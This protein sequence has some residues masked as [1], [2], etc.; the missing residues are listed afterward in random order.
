MTLLQF[1]IGSL[2]DLVDA[3]ADAG[4][5][6]GKPIPAGLVRPPE[7]AVVVVASAV[8][9]M[10]LA[11]SF[12]PGLAAVAA[13]GLAVGF[14]YDLR[15]KGTTISWL[16]L[17]VGIPLLPVFGWYGATGELP[18]MFLVVVPAAANA[19]AALAISNALVDMERDQDATAGS[20][21]I[22]LGARRAGL[23]VIGLFAVVAALAVGTAF[24]LGAPLGW[25]G[26]VAAACLVPLGGAVLGA[27][28]ARRPGT[29]W[30]ETAFEVQ[31]VGTGLVAVAWLGALSAAGQPPIAL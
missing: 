7:A 12:S 29:A 2:N 8:A 18:G 9:G 10:L 16:P 5:K 19:G 11:L 23:L 27:V 14:W 6:A 26:A 13:L 30:R 17:A 28:A 20:I 3:P 21:A 1:A 15:A 22:A 31:A 24:A 25:V 4:R